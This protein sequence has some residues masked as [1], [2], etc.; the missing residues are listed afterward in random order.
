MSS[1]RW[2]SLLLH[3]PSWL[4]INNQ[5]RDQSFLALS[6]TT[7]LLPK[8][9]WSLSALPSSRVRSV[10]DDDAAKF[11][12]CGS[13]HNIIPQDVS[14]NTIIQSKIYTPSYNTQEW[15]PTHLQFKKYHSIPGIHTPCWIRWQTAGAAVTDE[16]WKML[17]Q[18]HFEVTFTTGKV[19][20]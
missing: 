20:F 14:F 9:V 11:S 15:C 10:Y 17:S 16:G 5:Q 12:W 19:Y 1:C 18:F 8:V 7:L 6:C 3:V 4:A 13:K 2:S